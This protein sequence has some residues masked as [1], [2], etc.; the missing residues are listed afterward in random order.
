MIIKKKLGQHPD[1]A[2][3]TLKATLGLIIG[4]VFLADFTWTGKSKA[5]A[6]QKV[7]FNKYERLIELLY[8]TVKDLH[9]TIDY[10]KLKDDLVNRVL[11]YSYE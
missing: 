8:V 6:K 5:G 1:S 11:K 4:R 7:A 10:V 9:P 2:L 3:K